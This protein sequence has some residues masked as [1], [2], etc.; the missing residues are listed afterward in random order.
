MKLY[1]T[2]TRKVEKFEPLQKGKVSMYN[3]GPTVYW[4]MTVGNIRAYYFVDILRR[5]FE[6]FGYEVDQVM[7]LTDVGHLVSDE[8]TGE[9][10]LD[11]AAKKEGKDIWEIADFY[12]ESVKKDFVHM[13]YLTPKNFVRATDVIPEIIGFNKKIEENGFSYETPSALYYDVSKYPDYTRLQGGQ[14]L[15][16]KKTGVREEVNVDSDKKNPADFA[17]WLKTVGEHEHHIMKW[18]SPWGE[19]FP[20]WHI[21]CSAIG[22]KYLGEEFD[23]HTG[24]ED[25]IPVHHPNERAQNFAALGDNSVNYWVH[26]TFLK[27]D[28]GKMG[29]SLGNAYTLADVT[30]RGFDPMDLKYFYLTANY[31]T[32]QNFT[33]ENLKAAQTSRK[34]LM[35][36]IG[37]IKE[38]SLDQKGKVIDEYKKRF[39]E[40]LEDNLN[41]PVAL[42]VM[43]DLLKDKDEKNSDILATFE[44]FN[45]VLGLKI[46]EEKIEVGDKKK[47]EI[48]KLVSDRD[49]AREKKDWERSDTIR[50]QLSNMNVEIEDT[51]EGTK[52]Y[53]K[54]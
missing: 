10:K 51:S 26:N 45:L 32:K 5:T 42:S 15:E 50:D 44:D 33:W 27:V 53:I 1:N 25:H 18:N 47:N 24:G 29:K 23:I 7:N 52:W 19:G 28:G 40:A 35:D 34:I 49:E 36:R 41:T 3:C 30:E 37:K 20:G 46:E 39:V 4:H 17:L 48:E 21:E 38:A 6:Y 2:L 9:D 8:D 16:D 43:W 22:H 12:I 54:K 14:S 31:R 11:T 13:N